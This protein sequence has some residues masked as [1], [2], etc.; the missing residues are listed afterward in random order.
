MEHI[1]KNC[2][3]LMTCDVLVELSH[4]FLEKRFTYFVP[5]SL[6]ASI[7]VGKR[8]LVPFGSQ[9]LEGF[10]LALGNKEGELK[11]VLEVID[12]MPVLTDEMLL[13]GEVL[14]K[15][16]LSTLMCVYQ[17]MLPLALKARKKVHMKPVYDSYYRMIQK[18]TGKI[19]TA[20]EKI[21]ALFEKKEMVLKKDLVALSSSGLKTLVRN[22]YLLEVKKEKYRLSF[23][24]NEVV[25]MTLNE[26][27]AKA[28]EEILRFFDTNQTILLHGVTG[29]GKTN[30]Y[31]SVMDEVLKKKKQALVLVPEISLT[32]QIVERFHNHFTSRIAILHSGLSDGEKYDEWRRIQRGEVDIVIG[33]RSAIFAPLTS[34]GIIII[35][36]EHSSTYRQENQP[37]YDAIEVAKWRCK[38]HNCP[39]ILGSATPSLE[40]YARACKGV[41]HLVCLKQRYNQ[42]FPMIE[43][44]DLNQE[45]KQS[46]SYFSKRLLEEIKVRLE[47]KEQIILFLNRR[48][49]TSFLTCQNCGDV[50]K[51]PQC[52]IT[53]TFHKS[54]GMLRCHYC[55]YA[56]KKEAFCKHCGGEIKEFGMGTER[57]MEELQDIFPSARILRMD[58]DTTVQK[59]AHAKMIQAFENQ[60]YDILIGTQMI[61]K[62]LDFP[63]VTLVGIM[64]ADISL[65]LPDYRAS[66]VT[67]SLLNQ[68]AGRSGRGE[69]KGLVLIQTW[70]PTHYAIEKSR[71]DDYE[72][73]YMEEMRLR[74]K[75]KY[76]PYYYLATLFIIS[77]DYTIAS[78]ESNK[79]FRF[80]AKEKPS[81]EILLGPSPA[82]IFRIKNEY[83]FQIM[84]KYKDIDCLSKRL[85][86]LQEHY[87]SKKD[88]R[89]EIDLHHI[90]S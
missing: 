67:F 55:G 34:I 69:K 73:F 84:V 38:Y 22:G 60:E 37:K 77:K 19:S 68:V 86:L 43:T 83:R 28:K 78:N 88:V 53:L 48:G 87:F 66:E 16:T 71:Q 13:L 59:N 54:S 81:N 3:N 70:N 14:R 20:Q 7:A 89:L 58:V 90:Y 15:W 11:S 62:G 36:E 85:L 8:V 56:T 9:T 57:L 32:P 82:S 46:G 31:M 51:C 63:N 10:V 25:A 76:P 44:I 2:G 47:R 65:H 21:I 5:S 1:Q 6:Q 52:D 79:V 72:G 29:S 41:Y 23:D 18:P 75:L 39:L 26:E 12:E 40:S 35:D 33:A 24:K 30:V 4:V 80:L 74:K 42:K 45:M 64:N 49:Y 61:A 50:L 17:A 27:Q